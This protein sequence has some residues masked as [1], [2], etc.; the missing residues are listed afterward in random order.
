MKCPKCGYS[1]F[2]YLDECKRCSAYLVEFKMKHNI[3]GVEPANINFLYMEEAEEELAE[4]MPEAAVAAAEEPEAGD[5]EMDLS[6]L[7]LEEELMPSAEES[8]AV[9]EA[10]SLEGEE[11]LSD[12]DLGELEPVEGEE[13]GQAAP[14]ADVAEVEEEIDL[15]DLSA[16][17]GEVAAEE[18]AGGGEVPEEEVLAASGAVDLSDVEEDLGLDEALEEVAVG[19]PGTG[20]P[21]ATELKEPTE[22]DV[23]EASVSLDRD[24]L[25]EAPAAQEEAPEVQEEVRMEGE[26]GAGAVVEERIFAPEETGPLDEEL[27]REET[28]GVDL[29]D[30]TEKAE[31]EPEAEREVPTVDLG[32]L[33]EDEA[34][35]PR[36]GPT[37][38]LSAFEDL[39]ALDVE[40]VKEEEEPAKERGEGGKA[41]SGDIEAAG[42]EFAFELDE[43]KPA[44][45]EEDAEGEE[46]E[47]DKEGKEN[48]AGPADWY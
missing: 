6:G 30:I 44:K 45:E 20:E 24:T 40:V 11:G 43:D 26:E 41:P 19:E 42:G 27:V 34:E 13:A 46:D 48:K 15:G 29:V 37:V 8:A 36:E 35:T 16:A 2:S 14:V 28:L 22:D 5:L 10:E 25:E 33:D 23:L 39:G 4:E 38:D 17:L 21:P 12:L 18:A 9:S 31:E 32:G 7:S 3:W 47:E 1:S